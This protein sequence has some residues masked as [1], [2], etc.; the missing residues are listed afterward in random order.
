[1]KFLLLVKLTG[2][3]AVLKSKGIFNNKYGSGAMDHT[4]ESCD[5]C[6]SAVK[7][8]AVKLSKYSFTVDELVRADFIG[9]IEG[10]YGLP[11]SDRSTTY[12][13]C[14]VLKYKSEVSAKTI[15]CLGAL[16]NLLKLTG[17]P[18]VKFGA[19]NESDTNAINEWSSGDADARRNC[20][21]P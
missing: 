4:L 6:A 13:V 7:R 15:E 1:M 10:V 8:P 17:E 5:D 9:P 2:M 11:A 12:T 20:I 16:L 21:E 19:Y 14:Y 3:P 18:I